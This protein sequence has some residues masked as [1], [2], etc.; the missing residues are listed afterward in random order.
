MNINKVSPGKNVPE[1]I[2]VFIEIPQGGSIKYEL[3]KESGVI[4]V[5]RFAFT[6]MVYPFNYGFIPGTH[7]EDGDPADVLVISSYAVLPGVVIPSRPIGML[8]MT[9]EAGIDTKIIAVPT[10][11]VDPFMSKINEITDLDEV[12]LKKIQHFFNHYKELEKG[13]WVKTKDFLGKEKAFEA[14]NKSI[15]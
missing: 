1:E 10:V 8:E 12:T 4:M 13:K 5:D 7:A 3:D 15:K 6:A 14:I 9:D 11:K 2:N